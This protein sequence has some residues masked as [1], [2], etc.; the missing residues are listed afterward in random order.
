MKTASALVSLLLVVT[1]ACAVEVGAPAPEFAL[2]NLQRSVKLSDFKG[3]T[4]YLDFWASWCGPCKQSFPWM[5]AMHARYSAQGLRVFAINVD[6]KPADAARFLAASPA[7]FD[8]GYDASG[9]SPRLYAVKT[10]P[11]SYLIDKN[12][13]LLWKHAGFSLKDTAALE[14]AIQSALE[15]KP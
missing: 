13:V 14:L 8:V 7:L 12:G 2:N 6:Q 5:N 1:H 11:T 10:M 15:G 3:K 4:V 9:A